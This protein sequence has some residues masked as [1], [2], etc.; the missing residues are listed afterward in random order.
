MIDED[1]CVYSKSSG[2]KF[3][4]MILYVDDI[5]I[6]E[7]NIKYLKDIKSW[8][9]SNFKLKDMGDVVYILGVKIS[10]DYSRRLL[11]LS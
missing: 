11:S 9:S 6:A 7:N 2:S 1:H 5:L 4:I 3:I 10:R 8:L